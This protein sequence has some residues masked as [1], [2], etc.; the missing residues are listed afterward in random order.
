MRFPKETRALIH[1]AGTNPVTVPWPSGA[2]E[3]KEGR[4]YWVQNE[5]DVEEQERKAKLRRE[6][7]PETHAEVLAG[8]HRRLYGTESP[9]KARKRRRASTGRPQSGDDRI[10]VIA[11]AVVGKTDWEAKVVVHEDP[12]PVRHLG[13]K[14]K[15]PGG[16]VLAGTDE[17]FTQATELEPEQIAPPRSRRQREEEEDALRIEHKAS[18]DQAEIL[19]AEQHLLDQRRRGKTGT[20]AEAAL[21]RARRRAE[22]DGEAA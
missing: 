11:S 20:L 10:L 3:P 12:D 21:A 22:Y 5:E 6:Y 13:I 2:G 8:M 16:Q 4:L 9:V 1:A 7:S 19:K 15:V 17:E 18:I 14:T